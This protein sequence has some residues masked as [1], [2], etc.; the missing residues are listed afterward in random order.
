MAD[1]GFA[2]AMQALQALNQKLDV[3]DSAGAEFDIETSVGP[4][5]ALAGPGGQLLAD[6]LARFGNRFDGAEIGGGRIDHGLDE[7][8]QLAAELLISGGDASLDEHLELP[9]A[10]PALV[11]LARAIERD[12]DFSMSSIRTQA[13]IDAVAE[14]F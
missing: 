13:Q 5:A 14:A 10:P 12:A 1:P 11:I 9:I 3:S 6:A 8:Q 7:L 2:A 4:R